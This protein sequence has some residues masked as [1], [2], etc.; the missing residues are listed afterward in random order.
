LSLGTYRGSYEKSYGNVYYTTPVNGIVAACAIPDSKAIQIS[1]SRKSANHRKIWRSTMIIMVD[2]AGSY[3]SEQ[4]KPGLEI[5]EKIPA[6]G[7]AR[8]GVK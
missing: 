3:C 7:P 5:L 1:Q 6:K 8:G 2:S 4:D